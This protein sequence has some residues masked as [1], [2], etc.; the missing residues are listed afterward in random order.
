VALQRAL[1][2]DAGLQEARY[3]LGTS[4]MRLGKTSEARRELEIL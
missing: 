3:A 2:L 4:L 1:A